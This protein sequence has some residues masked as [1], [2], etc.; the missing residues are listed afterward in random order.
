MFGILGAT[1]S[2]THAVPKSTR[3]R[4]FVL[5]ILLDFPFI[6]YTVY[7]IYHTFYKTSS[8]AKKQM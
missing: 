7:I 4:L 6:V 3:K 5:L 2:G 8:G 1:Y